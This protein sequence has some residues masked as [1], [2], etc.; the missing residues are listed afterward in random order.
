MRKEFETKL[1]ERFP[2]FFIDLYGDPKDT[3]M[4]M[5]E[6]WFNLL[7]ETCEAVEKLKL[8]SLQFK[9]LQI[10]E[11][12][13]LANFYSSFSPAKNEE[14]EKNIKE[15]FEIIHEKEKESQKICERCGSRDE[16]E[17]TT[18]TMSYWIVTNCKKCRNLG[19]VNAPH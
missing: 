18:D 12:W 10:K 5:G 1:K 6:G 11:K 4:A 13:G 7:W 9:F 17:T 2:E 19:E 14:E 8:P 3:C 16:V 15:I